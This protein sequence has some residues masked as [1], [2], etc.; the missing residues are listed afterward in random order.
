ME[1][2]LLRIIQDHTHYIKE[3]VAIIVKGCNVVIA[4][5]ATIFS[6]VVSN[7]MGILELWVDHGK[8]NVISSSSLKCT[9][10]KC[11]PR[12]G[13]PPL[14]CIVPRVCLS[15]TFRHYLKASAHVRQLIV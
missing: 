6:S 15:M 3:F 10:K 14:S 13:A 2:S 4:A 11:T 9:Q 12:K 5:F 1:L 7:S 8:Q